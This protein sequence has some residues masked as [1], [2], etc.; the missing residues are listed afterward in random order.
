[1]IRALLPAPYTVLYPLIHALW[2]CLLLRQSLCGDN[3]HYITGSTIR[4]H[5]AG[6][7]TD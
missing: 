5:E 2:E 3:T 6:G 1:M 4:I 7:R